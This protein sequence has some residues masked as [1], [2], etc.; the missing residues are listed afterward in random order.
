M[1]DQ[2]KDT[3][4][5]LGRAFEEF[6]AKNDERI[7]QVEAKGT[8]D[9][10]LTAS[11]DAL[12]ERISELQAKVNRQSIG[13]DGGKP[14]MSEKMKAFHA[15]ARRGVDPQGALS[16]GT[17]SAGGFTVPDEFERQLIQALEVENVMRGLATVITSSSGIKEIPVVSAH[18]TATWTA[19]AAA[20]T[21][22]D[23]TFANV[24]L[25]AYKV[26]RLIRVS[27]ELLNDSAFNLESYLASEFG[28]SIGA[29]E[30]T[31]FVNGAGTTR[32]TGIVGGAGVG[33]TGGAGTA[34][35][36]TT[37]NLLDTYHSLG[38][39][40]RRNA[41]WMMRDATA[42][43]VRK[44]KDTTN[45]YLWQPGLVAGQPDLLLGRPIAI[46]DDVP[47]MAANARSIVFADVKY[48]WIADRTGFSLQRLSE[49][50]AANG[51]VGFIGERRVDGKL[52]LAAAAK[53]FVN[54]AT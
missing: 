27:K 22:S 26:S 19:E 46:S 44:L 3:I 18:G 20:H 7:K 5:T 49:L 53:V 37:D 51:Q 30:E 21:E 8:A 31:A 35:S 2:L 50:Y 54:G 42:L 13:V 29:A 48:Y 11:V 47:A 41:T 45:Q 23:E 43:A 38:R 1:S 16:V 15:Y 40:Y 28:R 4:E 12:N 39:Q 33:I 52:T 32:P 25:S 24:T 17:D 36:V 34:T 9:P 10:V 6:K 14:E